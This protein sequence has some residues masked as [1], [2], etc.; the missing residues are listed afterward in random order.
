MAR[1][2]L[3]TQSI[4]FRHFYVFWT[5]KNRRSKDEITTIW[6]TYSEGFEKKKKRWSGVVFF[7]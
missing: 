5:K 7:S 6:W 1:S 4:L 2:A 3:V